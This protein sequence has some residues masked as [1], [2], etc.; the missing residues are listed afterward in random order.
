MAKFPTHEQILAMPLRKQAVAFEEARHRARMKELQK[1]DA[2]LAL[3][4]TEHAALKAAGYTIYG[5]QVESRFLDKGAIHIS[6][7]SIFGSDA[8]L[9]K[10]LLTV[11]F[12]EVE[13]SENVWTNITFKKG[14]LRVR[15][16]IDAKAIARVEAEMAPASTPA[17]V[18]TASE[19]AA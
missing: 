8:C 5:S 17:P 4:E 12:K 14:R 1:A 13:R 7:T 11:G 3:L 6:V 18:A 19:V 2:A 9:Y 15:I 10:A 16:S